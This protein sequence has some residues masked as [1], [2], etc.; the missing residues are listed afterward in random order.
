MDLRQQLENVLLVPHDAGSEYPRGSAMRAAKTHV[1]VVG[2]G[3]ADYGDDGFGVL[4]ATILIAEGV[5]HV[6][7][8]GN[9]LE[10]YFGRITEC[11]YDRVLFVDAADFGA[12]PG[13]VV[14]LNSKEMSS[15]FP[16]V[17]TH[18][19]S[20]GL[21]AR[22]AEEQGVGQ[23]WLLGVQPESIRPGRQLSQKLQVTLEAI[24][25]LLCA[26]LTQPE[27]EPRPEI[28]RAGVNS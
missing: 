1:C 19:I 18:K 9:A 8:A 23:V 21:L 13:S 17:S 22:W 5:P 20:L 25:D 3:N 14:L 4:L 7:E 24:V 27:I 28:C 2:L 16:Q 6:I 11:K 10:R 12:P 15:R 26:I